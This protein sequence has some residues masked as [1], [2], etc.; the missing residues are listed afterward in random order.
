MD[1]DGVHF[2]DQKQNSQRE[3]SKRKAEAVVLRKQEVY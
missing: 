1:T 2:W 3:L